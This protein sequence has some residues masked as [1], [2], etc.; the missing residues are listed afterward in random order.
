MRAFALMVA[1]W[2]AACGGDGDD[3]DMT[4]RVDGVAIVLEDGIL[5]ITVY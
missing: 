5:V 2:L 1:L 4:Y 3:K